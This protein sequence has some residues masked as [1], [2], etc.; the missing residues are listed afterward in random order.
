MKKLQLV[1]AV[2]VL[3]S[4]S[5]VFSQTLMDYVLEQRGDTLVV[6]DYWD[7][8]EA[9]SLYNVLTLDT[10]DVPAGR[11]YML[12][13]GGYYPLA[14][15]PSTAHATVIVGEDDTRLVNND[16]ATAFPPLICGWTSEAGSNNGAF[17][18][19]HDLTVKNCNIIPATAQLGLGWNFFDGQA[20]NIK[21]TLD[22]CLFERTRWVFMATGASNISWHIKDSYFVNMIGQP[23]RRNGGVID[24]FNKQGTLLVENNTHLQA[25]GLMYKLRAN[26]FERVIFNHNTFVNISNLV[27]LDLGSQTAVSTT[28]NI[29]VNCNVQPYGPVNL[30]VGEEDKGGQPIGIANVYPDTS[31][32]GDRK[33]LLDNNVL[34]NDARLDDIAAILNNNLVNGSDQW[35]SQMITMNER[36][37]SYFDDD[38]TY[39][40][41]VEGTWYNEMPNFTD[42][43]DLLTTQVD[44]LKTFSAATVD[45]NSTDV[46]P[47]WRLVNT[48][49][50]NYVFVD[51]PIPVDL[52]Y[53]N[54]TLITGAM[55]GFPVG[56]LN[57][58]PTEKA[59]WMVQRDGEYTA[60]QNALDTGTTTPVEKAAGSKSVEFKLQQNYPNPFNP[61]TTIEYTINNPGLVTLKVYDALGKEV[62]TLVDGHKSANQVHQAEFDGSELSSG[63]YFY[64]LTAGNVT[65]T[66][67]MLMIK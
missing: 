57:W 45:T 7:M 12:K 48:G 8:N 60:I 14:N 46:M 20:A 64:T 65:Q 67:K 10:E 59:M 47:D 58:F 36:T 39:P 50:D 30:D 9:N 35:V 62:A 33:Y 43:Q 16:D 22:N 21:L 54:A 25:Q 19:A 56:D 5:V 3:L 29:F 44:I 31:V 32:H 52:S 24:V 66:N 15:N 55:G 53:D 4:T 17:Y 61:T 42:S 13:T 2:L 51:W 26:Q 37:Q 27:L 6:K 63:V 18:F 11:V 1:L 34:V 38:A 40:Y 23:C 49:D 28:N 41:L